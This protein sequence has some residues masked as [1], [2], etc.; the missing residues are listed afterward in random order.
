MT[1]LIFNDIWE[2]LTTSMM[3][4]QAVFSN[5]SNDNTNCTVLEHLETSMMVFQAG[6]FKYNNDNAY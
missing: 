1:M 6:F 3:V 5:N 2:H 4:F